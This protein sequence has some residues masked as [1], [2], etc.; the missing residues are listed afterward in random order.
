MLT[1]DKASHSL[2]PPELSEIISSIWS[3]KLYIFAICFVCAAISVVIAINTPNTYR[4]EALV[5]STESLQGQN[6][7]MGELGGLASL[8]GISN[9]SDN[10]FKT[11]VAQ[12]KMSTKEFVYEFISKYDL[13]AK[14]VAAK[15]WNEETGELTYDAEIFDEQNKQ[16]LL[17]SNINPNWLAYKEF[18][19]N[20]LIDKEKSGLL[21]I[22]YEHISPVLSQFIV[23]NLI[24]E[25]N[26]LMQAYDVKQADDSIKYLTE[27]LTQTRIAD[28]E[29]V[30]YKLIEEQTKNKMLNEI[31]SEYIFTTIDPAIVPEE[32]SGPKR[33]FIVV[34][35]II[36]GGILGCFI[37][38]IRFY[39]A[40]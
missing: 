20:L 31:K 2:P 4:A 27:K 13:V 32:K 34:V 23:E 11:E 35:S 18:T 38:L 21:V 8:A 1:N 9:L 40:R 6:Q 24:K 39:R 5:A 12:A 3:F 33:A 15:Q 10:D 22:S 30:F 17:P 26:A 29:A 37:A 28:M 14:L 25:I 19:D 16:F 36:L 7:S